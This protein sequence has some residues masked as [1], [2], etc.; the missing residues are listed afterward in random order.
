MDPDELS[1]KIR[2]FNEMVFK[3]EKGQTHMMK[4]E[5]QLRQGK[6]KFAMVNRKRAQQAPRQ[7]IG[8]VAKKYSNQQTKRAFLGSS[9]EEQVTLQKQ[10]AQTN[11]EQL[12]AEEDDYQF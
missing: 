7:D 3:A 8:D 1:D 5:V 6:S 10:E 2:E 9:S 11:E 12:G 4:V